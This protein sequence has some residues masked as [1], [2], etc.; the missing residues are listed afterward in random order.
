MKG[1]WAKKNKNG[2]KLKRE[3]VVQCFEAKNHLL[4]TSLVK[5]YISI[6]LKITNIYQV[7]QYQPFKCLSPFV[8]HVTTMRLDAE[9]NKKKTKAN[10]AKTFGNSGYGKVSF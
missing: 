4:M 10:S 6:G 5:F 3:T 1:Q 2:E 7:I 9:R 8:K